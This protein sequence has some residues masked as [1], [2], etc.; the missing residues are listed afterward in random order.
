MVNEK[1]LTELVD[2]DIF[3]VSFVPAGSQ[4]IGN[5][6]FTVVKASSDETNQEGDDSVIDTK[7]AVKLEDLSDEDRKELLSKLE[8][9]LK[10]DEKIS[11][12]LDD[13]GIT[14]KIQEKLDEQKPEDNIEKESNMTPKAREAIKTVI[15]TLSNVQ[16][17]IPANYTWIYKALSDLVDETAPDFEKE[18]DKQFNG[19]LSKNAKDAVNKSIEILNKEDGLSDA[20]KVVKDALQ[21]MV[22]E[23]EDEEPE[24]ELSKEAKEELVKKQEEINKL[25]DEKDKLEKENLEKELS[26]RVSKFENIPEDNESLT[27]MYMKL[28]ETDKELF[29]QIEKLLKKIDTQSEVGELF[30]EKGTSMRDKKEKDLSG[31]D[32]LDK[33]VEEYIEDGKAKNKAQA[34][35][36]ALEDNPDLYT[37]LTSD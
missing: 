12:V 7:E 21:G 8:N 36:K 23:K 24:E 4:Q 15:K 2:N 5:Q 37:E 29:E 10:D 19:K 1:E 30:K 16:H 3:E 26:E 25:K 9:E 20:T 6:G 17:E 35:T 28:H 31:Q 34:V 13:E 18:Q 22:F 32:K 14:E 27:R 33:I 11:L